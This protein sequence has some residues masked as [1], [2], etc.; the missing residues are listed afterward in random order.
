M[1]PKNDSKK[2]DMKTI[3]KNAKARTARSISSIS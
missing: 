3:I 1:F 2:S